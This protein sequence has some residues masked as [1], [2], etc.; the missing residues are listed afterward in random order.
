VHAPCDVGALRCDQE[1]PIPLLRQPELPGVEQSPP[2]L[3]ESSLNKTPYDRAHDSA[4]LHIN[5]VWDILSD[6]CR[7]SALVCYS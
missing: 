3:I 4:A 1:D 6:N 7:S 5:Q 2:D